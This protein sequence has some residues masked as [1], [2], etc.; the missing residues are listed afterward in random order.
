M[1][2]W[3]WVKVLYLVQVFLSNIITK[4][5]VLYH[6]DLL[7]VLCVTLLQIEFGLHIMSYSH[8]KLATGTTVFIKVKKYLLLLNTKMNLKMCKYTHDN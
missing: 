3:V 4:T 1:V 7:L 5:L 8:Y 2:M 6:P